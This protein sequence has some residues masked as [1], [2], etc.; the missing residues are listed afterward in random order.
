MSI[1]RLIQRTLL[2][3]EKTAW[4]PQKKKKLNL[5][6]L[7]IISQRSILHQMPWIPFFFFYFQVCYGFPI[8]PQFGIEKKP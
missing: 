5:V 3:V 6:P 8:G 4:C 7:D 2:S 1:Y